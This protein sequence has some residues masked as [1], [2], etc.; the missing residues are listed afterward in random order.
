[1]NMPICPRC[2]NAE[3]VRAKAGSGTRFLCENCEMFFSV[4][5]AQ[6][7]GTDTTKAL[8]PLKLFLSYPHTR[9]G[10]YNICDDIAAFLRSRGHEVWF[11]EEQ[12]GGHHG[13]DWRRKIVSG[14]Q[15]S[16]LVLSC[17][18][19]HAI[20]VENGRRGVCLDELSIAISVKGGNINTVLLEAEKSVRPSA[21]LSHRQW[22]DM[23]GWKE[24]RAAGEEV[25][26]PWLRQK[27]EEIARMVESEDNYTFDG[28]ISEIAKKLGMTDY[29]LDRRE[30]LEKPFIGREWLAEE[31]DRWLN[32]ENDGKKMTLCALY[33][34]P[35]LGK[36]AFAV[37]YAF[38]SPNVGA[39]ICFE[40]SNPHYNSVPAMVRSLAYQL[41]CRLS[42]YRSQLLEA[43]G[44]PGV[45]DLDDAELFDQLLVKPMTV[46]HI[47]GT[48]ENVCII[49]DALDECGRGEENAVATVLGQCVKK[50]P[51]WLKVLVTSRRENAVLRHIAPD[52]IID[53]HGSDAKNQED[54]RAYYMEVLAMA[55]PDYEQRS[56][57]AELLT[58]RSSGA[59]LYAHLTAEAVAEGFLDPFEEQ[60]FPNEMSQ[61]LTMWMERL[62]P[63]QQEYEDHF[64]KA[65]GVI[66]A[67]PEPL[68]AEE[69]ERLLLLSETETRDL[70]RRIK[71]FLTEGVNTFG[72]K[73]IAF[74]HRYV[75]DWLS[76]EE[77]G[78]FC[79][80]RRDA[81]RV[82]G[83]GCYQSFR[84][85]LQG[86]SDYELLHIFEFLQQERM[87]DELNA[88]LLSEELGNLLWNRGEWCRIW[89]KLPQADRMFRNKLQNA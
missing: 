33:G 57:T 69:L 55:L 23:S 53:V 81:V 87:T 83:L 46:R 88:V 63:D 37:H 35:G 24:K 86:M 7:T 32:S 73:T 76:S 19:R 41:A 67:S 12:L 52:R 64:R 11:D 17:L 60:R 74:E 58:A 45:M 51:A 31:V 5:A 21:A 3:Y 66:L 25:Y 50:F 20:R 80:S 14:I 77:A 68:P 10:E 16:Q 2:G 65:I 6:D 4:E 59:F 28:E 78:P 40:A 1:M 36:S 84:T 39:I 8:K 54:I 72:K 9:Q 27:L 38:S 85:D 71:V 29:R 49:L 15:E 75:Q 89:G 26:R 13:E 34:D 47:D 22:L 79:V 82:M 56:R 43:V 61:T 62:F 42:D 48:H 70:K 44:R 18:N 30:L